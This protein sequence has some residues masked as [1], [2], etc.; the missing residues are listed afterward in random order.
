[1]DY[2]L[3]N[4]ED[5]KRSEGFEK[6]VEEP[7]V[8]MEILMRTTVVGGGGVTLRSSNHTR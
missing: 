6:L 8:L 1:M 7:E 5:V 3:E 4:F 2:V